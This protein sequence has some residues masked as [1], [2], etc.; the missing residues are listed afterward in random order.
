MKYKLYSKDFLIWKHQIA[1]IPSLFLVVNA[2]ELMYK[3]FSITFHFL[4]FNAR[5]L[6]IERR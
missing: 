4:V 2:P 5:L 6:F 1:F 3:N